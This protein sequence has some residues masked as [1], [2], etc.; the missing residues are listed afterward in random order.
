MFDLVLKECVYILGGYPGIK[1][2]SVIL[3]GFLV[4][5]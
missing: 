1:V 4:S 5:G 2:V 3:K